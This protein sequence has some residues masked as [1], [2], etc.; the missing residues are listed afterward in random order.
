[1]IF[2]LGQETGGGSTTH[3]E[4]YPSSSTYQ[5]VTGQQSIDL[6]E[7]HEYRYIRVNGKTNHTTT[8]TPAVNKSNNDMGASHSYRYV[9]TSGMYKPSG[10]YSASVTSNKTRYTFNV[11]DYQT[12]AIQVEVTDTIDYTLNCFTTDDSSNIV[13]V[14]DLYVEGF[15]KRI[16][17]LTYDFYAYAQSNLVT[18]STGT[19]GTINNYGVYSNS[20]YLQDI[21]ATTSG[22]YFVF[23]WAI[24]PK[25]LY[26]RA[27]LA[28]TGESLITGTNPFKGRFWELIVLRLTNYNTS[29][30]S[31][32]LKVVDVVT[33]E[34]M[35]ATSLNRN[36]TVSEGLNCKLSELQNLETRTM[37]NKT[38][39]WTTSEATTMTQYG[40]VYNISIPE[41]TNSFVTA[42]FGYYII[43]QVNGHGTD[44]YQRYVFKMLY[45][46]DGMPIEF[47]NRGRSFLVLLYLGPTLTFG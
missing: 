9:N 23:A 19:S 32:N 18:I 2:D 20:N 17:S 31:P 25:Q 45:L 15:H 46:M 43:I 7:E 22:F 1:M 41:T 35:E 12:A 40:P 14:F 29:Y 3:T 39:C 47:I 37:V 13:G 4:S 42:K 8:Y 6:G 16:G 33:M 28:S 34:F 44:T 10:T 27:S 36:M 21:Q 11:R 24:T 30:L 38:N 5:D 26:L